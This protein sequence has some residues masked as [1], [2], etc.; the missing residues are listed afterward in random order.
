MAQLIPGKACMT[1]DSR[2]RTI[3]GLS[4]G[5][6]D[7]ADWFPW[8]D[9]PTAFGHWN[10]VFR[11]FRRWAVVGVFKRVFKVLRD[12]P[13]F[14]YVSIQPIP[15]SALRKSHRFQA[16]RAAANC[17]QIRQLGRKQI[18]VGP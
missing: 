18:G 15:P 9:L 7:C 13:K 4:K 12:D 16:L 2:G 6:L 8:R 17:Y 10:S 1:L 11:R 3:D 5:T 14:G